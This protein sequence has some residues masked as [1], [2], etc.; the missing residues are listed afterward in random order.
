MSKTRKEIVQGTIDGSISLS[1]AEWQLRG[2]YGGGGEP[3]PYQQ[4]YNYLDE[5]AG[6]LDG[7]EPTEEQHAHFVAFLE[8]TGF[9]EKF[10]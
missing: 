6:V 7:Q 2:L 10:D 1:Q 8:K 3:S 5:I 4:V 9:P